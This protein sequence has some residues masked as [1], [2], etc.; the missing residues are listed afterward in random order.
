MVVL[1]VLSIAGLLLVVS[2]NGSPLQSVPAVKCG[3]GHW[4]VAKYCEFNGV[5]STTGGIPLLSFDY[6]HDRLVTSPTVSEKVNPHEWGFD[7]SDFS[8]GANSVS[9]SSLLN[10]DEEHT[11]VIVV[12]LPY[13]RTLYQSDGSNYYVV[14]M[15]ILLPLYYHLVKLLQ[16]AP[17]DR[18]GSDRTSE[19]HY[20]V[21]LSVMDSSSGT[22][23]LDTDAFEDPHL[24]WMESLELLFWGLNRMESAEL[25]P[26]AESDAIP[27]V[28]RLQDVAALL[29]SRKIGGHSNSDSHSSF[30]YIPLCRSYLATLRSL[31][32]GGA[33]DRLVLAAGATT[34]GLPL[35]ALDSSLFLYKRHIARFSLL[36]RTA[37]DALSGD[38]MGSVFAGA[39]RRGRQVGSGAQVALLSRGQGRR[40]ILNEASLV[41]SAEITGALTHSYCGDT[42]GHVDIVVASDNGGN[43]VDDVCMCAV[44]QDLVIFGGARAH[45]DGNGVARDIVALQS[46]DVLVGL[47]GSGMLNC[48]Y[49]APETVC[50]II[51][52]NNQWPIVSGDPLAMLRYKHGYASSRA[53]GTGKSAIQMV[54]VHVLENI[55]TVECDSS[56]DRFCD[57]GD[58]VLPPEDYISVSTS[59]LTAFRAYQNSLV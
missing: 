37:A 52:L 21:I 19:A 15:D 9:I 36:M 1:L 34:V 25:E 16:R 4:P 17:N 46:V 49:S 13:D 12:Q 58:I 44:T 40:K 28:G 18:S 10:S 38:G 6:V 22:V 47:Q 24:F 45:G 30:S 20:V 48:L 32:P 51:Y 42:G 23:D 39:Q 31:V 53:A 41:R 50:A 35:M 43:C 59:A 8:F 33:V 29:R 5:D 56:T 55:S 57:S 11:H 26:A 14:H 27:A 2:T 54:Q 3:Q 7:T